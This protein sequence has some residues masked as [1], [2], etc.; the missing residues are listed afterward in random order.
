MAAKF[1]IEKF[2]GSNFSVW[3]LKIKEVLRKDNCAGTIEGKP[4]NTI[5]E[6]WKENDDNTVSKLHLAMTNSVLSS[7]VKKKIAKEI[8]DA[9]SNCTRSMTDHINQLNTLFAQL[10]AADFN[11]VENERAELLL[12]SLPDSYDQLIINIKNNNVGYLSFDDVVGAILEEE[13]RQKNK[14]ERLESSKQVEALMVM[15]GRS[16]ERGSSGSQNHY[17]SNSRSKK[18]FKCYYCGKKGHLKKEC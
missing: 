15:R 10:S 2:K 1:E 7:V 9:F 12:Q 17:R 16:T 13:S 4:I 11:I 14:E 18:N 3:K 8:C 5:E 6:R